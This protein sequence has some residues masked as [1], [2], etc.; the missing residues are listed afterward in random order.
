[1]NF[2]ARSIDSIK[3]KDKRYEVYDDN[4]TGFGIRISTNGNKSWISRYRKNNK[5]VKYTH[6]R[7][8]ILSLS[9]ARSQHNQL[10]VMLHDGKDPQAEKQ[11][12]KT[13]NLQAPTVEELVGLYIELYAKPN[14][15]SWRNDQ[16]SLQNYLASKYGKVKAKELKRQHITVLLDELIA[17]GMGAGANRVFAA[18]RKM[19]NWSV[20]KGILTETP[21]AHIEAPAKEN[22]RD[23]VLSNDEI[24]KFWNNMPETKL[25]R[26]YQIALMLLLVTAQRKSEVLRMS[27]QELDLE[28]GWW[29]IPADRSKNK[30]QHRVPLSTLALELIHEALE[31]SVESCYLFPSVTRPD[32]PINGDTLSH[33]LASNREKLGV[34]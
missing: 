18:I 22:S 29:V 32:T 2:T 34:S 10:R 16:H 33:A 20:S 9:D 19:F 12:A 23:R 28:H 3:P 25:K 6:G 17:N 30:L 4:E 13:E 24:D 11:I 5:L 14:K 27:K 8:P 15:R 1:M 21:C 26:R 7:Y 31:L